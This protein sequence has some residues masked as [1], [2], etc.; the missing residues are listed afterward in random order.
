[1]R[2]IG[3]AVVVF[4]A[5]RVIE[6]AGWINDAYRLAGQTQPGGLFKCKKNVSTE[7]VICILHPGLYNRD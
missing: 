5:V 1:M 3:F 4:E 7:Q 2:L 6:D